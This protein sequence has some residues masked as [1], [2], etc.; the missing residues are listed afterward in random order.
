VQEKLLE[1]GLAG[2]VMGLVMYMVVKPLVNALL[3]QLMVARDQLEGARLD[4]ERMC[5][6][7]NEF[8]Q[9]SIGALDSLK[10]S[11]EALVQRINDG[12]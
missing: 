8:H 5:V 10:V 7:H 6:A 4:R 2:A 1:F 12:R 3:G 9:R 11:M